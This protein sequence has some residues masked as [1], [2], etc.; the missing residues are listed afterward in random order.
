MFYNVLL[1]EIISFSL[2]TW[3]MLSCPNFND[4][5]LSSMSN[6][7]CIGLPRIAKK[8]CLFLQDDINW[9]SVFLN[10]QNMIEPTIVNPKAATQV[11]YMTTLTSF[12]F[13]SEMLKTK[14]KMSIKKGIFCGWDICWDNENN[15]WHPLTPINTQIWQMRL[16]IYMV[17]FTSNVKKNTAQ[18]SQMDR[19]HWLLKESI[20]IEKYQLMKWISVYPDTWNEKLKIVGSVVYWKQIK[21]KLAHNNQT[22]EW[23]NCCE[24]YRNHA[25][26]NNIYKV[27]KIEVR[28]TCIKEMFLYS[29]LN[30]TELT[31]HLV[32]WHSNLENLF[33]LC[34]NFAK[35]K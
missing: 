15:F 22:F 23:I 35:A 30:N 29:S 25:F 11:I 19:S 21:K 26:K 27:S 24:C 20:D 6:L 1:N 34:N 2:I 4:R 17:A 13:W 16:S 5:S 9:N 7:T 3:Y 10:F 14:F 31:I 28:Y 32:I 33:H 8:D 18:Q 12:D